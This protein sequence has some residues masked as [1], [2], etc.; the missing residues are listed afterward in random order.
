MIK[1][2]VPQEIRMM[3]FEEVYQYRNIN[4]YINS[5]HSCYPNVRGT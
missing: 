2:K 5:S 4:F 1:T 3:R